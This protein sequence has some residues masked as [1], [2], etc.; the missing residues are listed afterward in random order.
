V[1]DSPTF[2]VG[3]S[4]PE[5]KVTYSYSGNESGKQPAN[6][7]LSLQSNDDEQLIVNTIASS[8]GDTTMV[9]PDVSS[10]DT[11]YHAEVV[12]AGSWQLTITE[13]S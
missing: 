12:A 11:T 8:G 13:L 7:A 4:A 2:Q 3:S 1:G 5:L 6:F 9:Y 10:G